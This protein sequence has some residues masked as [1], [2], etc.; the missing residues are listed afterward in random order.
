MKTIT[1]AEEYRNCI[2]EVKNTGVTL[3]VI[4]EMDEDEQEKITDE[5]MKGVDIIVSAEC[6]EIKPLVV[7]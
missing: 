5:D 7:S 3:K 2:N 4:N 1:T 6:D